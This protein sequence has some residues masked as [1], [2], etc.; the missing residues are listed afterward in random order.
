MTKSAEVILSVTIVKDLEEAS[1][2]EMK[3]MET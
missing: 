1:A 2:M 3:E